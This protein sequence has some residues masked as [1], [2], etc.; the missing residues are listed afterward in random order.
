MTDWI[1]EDDI[2]AR[3]ID[4]ARRMAEEAKKA[5]GSKCIQGEHAFFYEHWEGLVPGHIYSRLGM[6]EFRISQMCE[7][8]FDICTKEPEYD[9]YQEQSGMS[10]GDDEHPPTTDYNPIDRGDGH[11]E[12]RAQTFR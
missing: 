12:G 5:D 2:R 9:N 3:H 11:Y 1:N 7:Y 8:H 6:D 10:W 4:V